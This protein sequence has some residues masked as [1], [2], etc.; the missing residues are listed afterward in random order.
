ME[1]H[2]LRDCLLGK[3]CS[4]CLC[5][6]Q[7]LLQS[8]PLSFALIQLPA[9]DAGNDRRGSSRILVRLCSD[10]ELHPRTRFVTGHTYILFQLFH[11]VCT[12]VCS[13]WE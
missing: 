12:S 7:L 5:R 6:S 3:L 1:K 2:L 9:A 10:A 11:S 13:V 8:L 4:I